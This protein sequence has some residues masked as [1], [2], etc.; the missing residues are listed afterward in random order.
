MPGGIGSQN[1][2]TRYASTDTNTVELGS[3]NARKA[4]I[5]AFSE[6]LSKEVKDDRIQVSVVS[7]GTADTG[8][9]KAHA[10]RPQTRDLTD[11]DRMLRPRD[12]AEAVVWVLKASRHVASVQVVLEPL[13]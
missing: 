2:I 5:M 4:A 8:F 6:S 13:G 3:P 7:P 1:A 10:G 12:V 9:R 11:P